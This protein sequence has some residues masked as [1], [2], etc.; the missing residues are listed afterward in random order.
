MN[1]DGEEKK[2][3]EYIWEFQT[4]GKRIMFWQEGN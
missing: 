1:I 3:E 4:F 2:C